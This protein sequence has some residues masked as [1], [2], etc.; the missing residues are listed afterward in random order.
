MQ[1]SLRQRDALFLFNVHGGADTPEWVGES[2]SFPK[3]CPVVFNPDLIEDY[4][5]GLILC[6]ACYGGAMGYE[7][8][9]VVENIFERNGN[10][11]VGCSVI[12]YGTAD[13][14]LSGADHIAVSC[15]QQLAEGSTLAQALTKAKQA[16]LETY[17]EAEDDD[18]EVITKTI[19]SFNAYGAPRIKLKT[20]SAARPPAAVGLRPSRPS[21]S[22]RLANMRSDLA[23][24]I[25][26]R[27]E[28]IGSR[29]EGLRESYRQKLPLR[30]QMF[31]VGADETL[32]TIRAFKDA[33]VIEDFLK[34]RGMSFSDCRLEKTSSGGKNKFRL[35]GASKPL[36]NRRVTDSFILITDS[37]GRLKKTILSKGP[38]Q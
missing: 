16:L 14:T 32:A 35:S 11:F 22:D 37:V 18:A 36:N 23:S 5:G 26:D 28:R 7:S 24:R 3:D 29:M 2:E 19:L 13:E 4:A 21:A 6:E 15:L 17:Y 38:F 8:P 25:A 12:A 20:G 31:L 30:S 10:G 9:S 27:R 34:S 33:S 1:A